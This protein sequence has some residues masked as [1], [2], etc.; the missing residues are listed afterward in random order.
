VQGNFRTGPLTW[1]APDSSA[2]GL[3][4]PPK[5]KNRT[6]TALSIS[7]NPAA[8]GG[9]ATLHFDLRQ[10][11]LVRVSVQDLA[12]AERA[13]VLQQTHLAAGAQQLPLPLQQLPP[14]LY[15]VLTQSRG[16]REHVRLEVR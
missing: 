13:V 15:L 7:P 12:G 3:G 14:G 5:A 9:T 8:T 4:T 10:A 6:V 11:G 1:T 2:T 16:E